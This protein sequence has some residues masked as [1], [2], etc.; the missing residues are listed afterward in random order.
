MDEENI[1]GERRGGGGV[2][3]KTNGIIN[4][5]KSFEFPDE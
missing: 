4:I 2:W 1:K 3:R 5:D